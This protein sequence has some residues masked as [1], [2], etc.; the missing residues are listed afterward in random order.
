MVSLWPGY[1][2][3]GTYERACYDSL[4][5]DIYVSDV[6]A[7][8]TFTRDNLCSV[9]EFK[10]SSRN[11]VEFL[12]NFDH[13]QSGSANE[14]SGPEASHDYL[15]DT[16]FFNVCLTVRN[17]HGCEDTA[18]QLV[19]ARYYE[20]ATLYNVFTPNGDLFND[21]FGMEMINPELYSLRIYNRWG[22]LVFM[23]EDPR[24]RW[25]GQLFNTGEPLPD[26]DYFYV[27]R[28]SFKCTNDLHES[29]GMVMLIR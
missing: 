24:L 3:Q 2:P 23:S 28:Y 21:D 25:N 5:K 9:F 22:E 13:P 16:G 14:V 26:G 27:F 18:C 12:W 20:F 19:E 17:V 8:L 29:Q 10:D 7:G 11:A 6:E 4:I 15:I 1:I